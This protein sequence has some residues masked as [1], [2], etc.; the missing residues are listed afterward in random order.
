MVEKELEMVGTW[1]HNQDLLD[2]PHGKELSPEWALLRFWAIFKCQFGDTVS[3]AVLCTFLHLLL[4]CEDKL[5][6]VQMDI[7]WV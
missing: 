7:G 6:A 2:N 1:L 4:L 5:V 3:E